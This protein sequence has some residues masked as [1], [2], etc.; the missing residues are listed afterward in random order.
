MKAITTLLLLLAAATCLADVGDPQS[1]LDLQSPEDQQ[2]EY[3]VILR[4]VFERA[5]GDDVVVT[6][7]FVPSFIPERA[8]GI[9]RSSRGYEAFAIEPSA[10]TWEVEYDRFIYGDKRVKEECFD[11]KGNKIPC[12]KTPRKKGLPESYRG[13]KTSIYRRPMPSDIAE[14]IKRLWQA[15][16]LEALHP[17]PKRNDSDRVLML[18]GASYQYSMRIAGHGL[19]TAEGIQGD[20]GTVARVMG[21]LAD[22]LAY[23]AYGIRSEDYLKKAVRR[24]E[25]RHATKT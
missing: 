13:I 18:D 25:A 6:A 21:D 12:T 20:K 2:D 7:L 17:P 14:N 23:Y 3:N 9:L 24:A 8:C 4:K 16:L 22:A 5:Y 19:V 10:S 11:T 15:K 1:H